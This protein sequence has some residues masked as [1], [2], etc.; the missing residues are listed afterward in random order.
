MLDAYGLTLM[1]CQLQRECLIQKLPT[2][3]PLH[4][5]LWFH[6]VLVMAQI[7]LAVLSS[8]VEQIF[9]LNV[10]GELCEQRHLQLVGWYHRIFIRT[11]LYVLVI[12]IYCHPPPIIWRHLWTGD[13]IRDYNI[14][15]VLW[16]ITFL[17]HYTIIFTIFAYH[18]I[19]IYGK[20]N[21]QNKR[22]VD[23]KKDEAKM[24]CKKAG[25]EFSIEN[26]YVCNRHQP[27][28]NCYSK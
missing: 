3:C 21:Q 13:K 10:F 18:L 19:Y 2:K 27:A 7:N 1:G 22:G 26:S 15:E 25:R 17:A 28:L 6:L 5:N 8:T 12:R 14:Q 23:R 9:D 4:P 11:E 20:S 16:Y 24:V